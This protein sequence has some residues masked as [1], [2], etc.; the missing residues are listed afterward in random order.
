MSTEARVKILLS[1][2]IRLGDFI[3]QKPGPIK[4][5]SDKKKAIVVKK[6]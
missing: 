5:N 1:S 6:V 4:P 3:F 2:F